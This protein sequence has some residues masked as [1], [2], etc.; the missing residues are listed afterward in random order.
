MRLRCSAHGRHRHRNKICRPSR[1]IGVLLPL[2]DPLRLFPLDTFRSF[3]CVS[4]FFRAV[5]VTGATLK[6][7]GV[8][9]LMLFRTVAAALGCAVLS[10]CPLSAA[11]LE[12]PRAG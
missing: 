12:P 5:R 6:V 2:S 3:R 1:G 10:L 11:E 9:V 4:T 8:T 7:Y